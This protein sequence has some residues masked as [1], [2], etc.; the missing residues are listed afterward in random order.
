MAEATRYQATYM[1]THA[2]RQ[3][4]AQIK[5]PGLRLV[6]RASSVPEASWHLALLG[7]YFRGTPRRLL[8]LVSLRGM[9]LWGTGTVLAAYF[10]GAAAVAWLWGR[11]PYN[12]ITYADLVLPTRWTQLREKRGQGQIDQGVHAIRTGDY[13]TGL[14]LLTNGLARKPAAIRG[15]LVLA[16]AY[17]NMGY[18]HRGLQLLEDGLVYG[19][20]LK[21][22]RES[23]FGLT[24][25][26]EDHERTLGLAEQIEKMLPPDDRSTRRWLLHQRIS[27]LENLQRDG[28]IER[29]RSELMAAPSFAL[30]AAWARVQLRRGRPAD[31]LREIARDPERFGL[32]ADRY[33]LQVSLAIAARDAAA[34]TAALQAWLKAEPTQP[35]PRIEQIVALIQLDQ[36]KAAR[37]L[38]PLFFL[39]FSRDR[40]AVILLMKKL[41][42]LP[43]VGWLQAAHREAGE[44]GAQGI[45]TRILYVQGLIM[46]GNISEA[47][48]EFN[49]TTALIDQAKLKD[50]GWSD[51]TRR[52]L[53]VIISDSPSNRAQF[54]DFFRSHRLS[55]EAYRFA[56]RS[57]RHAEVTEVA[58]EL[59]LIA[60]NRFPAMQD[61]K[62]AAGSTG[63]RLNA[64]EISIAVIRNEAEARMELR[65]IDAELKAGSHPAAFARLKVLERAGIPALDAELLLRRI[66]VQGALGEQGELSAALQLYLSGPGVS[67]DWLRQLAVRWKAEQ[68][69]DSAAT[70][71]RET[72]ARFPLARWAMEFLDLPAAKIVEPVEPSLPVVRNEADVRVELRN[73]DEALTA[74]RYQEAL[75]RIKALE[76]TRIAPLPELLLR[77]ILAHGSLR[78]HTE[79]S[80]ALGY[81]FSGR[82]VDLTALRQ[83]ATRWDNAEDRDSALI[84]LHEIQGRFPQ[85]RWAS[86]LR[87]KIEGDLMIAPEK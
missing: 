39:N 55:P 76:R 13:S 84:L 82:S 72:Y 22:Y 44:S 15:R 60:R 10:L 11:N 18:L 53:G 45:E 4:A 31:A 74:G 50:G 26:L 36:A 75:A 1:A 20:P 37:D 83:L 2:D 78:E 16:Q 5:M 65:R 52:L 48:A 62:P 81:Y 61:A 54:L 7:F 57:L 25:Y 77:R 19:P 34:A 30:E 17:V 64:G 24:R 69:P 21:L 14:I 71:A 9:M 23:L 70:L 85:A 49:L 47:L 42:E 51:G 80:A 32:P 3:P 56:L 58:E 28:E 40:G 6:W 35:Q 87:K 12:Y 86:D 46:A 43:D 79:L 38:L 41:G 33:Q 68:Q 27:A 29:L 8:I 59:A 66:Q 63:Q 67:Q 73:I